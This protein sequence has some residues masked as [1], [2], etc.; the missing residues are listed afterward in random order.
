MR[1][2]LPLFRCWQTNYLVIV[3]PL[4]CTDHL[5]VLDLHLSAA[6]DCQSIPSTNDAHSPLPELPRLFFRS[7]SAREQLGGGA[8]GRQLLPGVGRGATGGVL[9]GLY[10][11][12]RRDRDVLQH[13]WDHLHILLHVWL[14]LPHFGLPLQPGRLQPL[15]TRPQLHH[16]YD[17]QPPATG[18]VFSILYYLYFTS[19]WLHF[20]AKLKGRWLQNLRCMSFPQNSTMALL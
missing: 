13:H 20:T 4:C 18:F 14:H 12:R 2:L 3:Q 10:K 6:A 5:L 7:M 19:H 8:H 1:V 15:F 17:H 16:Q 9:H 11:E